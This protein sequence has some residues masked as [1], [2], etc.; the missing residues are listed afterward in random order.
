MLLQVNYFLDTLIK[1]QT[2]VIPREIK[3][4][5]FD[6]HPLEN[7]KTAIHKLNIDQT[8]IAILAQPIQSQNSYVKIKSEIPSLPFSD[9]ISKP[10]INNFCI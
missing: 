1:E 7:Y 3:V 8:M 4:E 10:T 9:H 5:T 2:E 6:S